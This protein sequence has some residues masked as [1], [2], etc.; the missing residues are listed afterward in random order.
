MYLKKHC[1]QQQYEQ[2]EKLCADYRIV[3]HIH[4]YQNKK[5]EEKKKLHTDRSKSR[6]SN[7]AKMKT[8]Q[9]HKM[10]IM[11]PTSFFCC[12]MSCI[13]ESVKTSLIS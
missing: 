4:Q 11:E 7:R 10:K 1:L 5:Y 13:D 2:N 6:D 12:V 3:S 9:K 8:T